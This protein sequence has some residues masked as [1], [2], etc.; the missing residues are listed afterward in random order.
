MKTKLAALLIA[1]A[2]VAH[3][4]LIDL[5]PGGF[6]AQPPFP[7]VYQYW[8]THTWQHDAFALP[9]DLFTVT[10]IGQPQGTLSWDLTGT[11][12]RFHWLF[13]I[14]GNNPSDI[15]M[16]RVSSDMVLAGQGAITVNGLDNI[17]GFSAYGMLPGQVPDGGSTLLLSA[18]GLALL[19]VINSNWYDKTTRPYMGR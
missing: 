12:Y 10:G 11:G 15:D 7:P 9:N 8:L 16:Y 4:N 17:F 18:L 19:G 14:D 13:V 6:S 3:A 2:S 1:T 5:T